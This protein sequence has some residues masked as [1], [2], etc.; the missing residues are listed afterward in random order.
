M[1]RA[2]WFVFCFLLR[3]LLSLRYRIEVRGLGN[4]EGRL[5]RKGGTLFLPNHPAHMDPLFIMLYLWQRYQLR[6]LVIEYVFRQHWM[7]P[8][9]RMV[10]AL[11]IPNFETS[12]NQIKVRKAEKV[13]GQIAEGLKKGENFLLYPAGRLKSSRKEMIGGSSAAHAL[14]QECSDANVVLIRTT[15]LWGSSFSRALTG[16]SPDLKRTIARG[17]LTAL[18]K[19]DFLPSP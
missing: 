2:F 1:G 12:I 19:P 6:P 17:C 3:A 13:I 18:K 8:F 15:G 11:S 10:G 7:R 16:R 14:L 5:K 9:I 4:L